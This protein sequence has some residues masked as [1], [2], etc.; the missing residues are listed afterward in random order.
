MSSAGFEPAIP[1]INWLQTYAIKGTACGIGFFKWLLFLIVS[2]RASDSGATEAFSSC[3]PIN[4]SIKTCRLAVPALRD[5]KT[6]SQTRQ[7][8]RVS[9]MNG[10][11]SLR[12]NGSRPRLKPIRCTS[13]CYFE[14]VTYGPCVYSVV[15]LRWRET[16]LEPWS[17]TSPL[18]M[19]RVK[20]KLIWT[21]GGVIIDWEQAISPEETRFYCHFVHHKY[22]T[23]C[24]WSEPGLCFNK[25]ATNNRNV[26]VGHLRYCTP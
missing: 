17:L 22:H 10:M 1:A 2:T 23:D 25:P 16:V 7:V 8:A 4:Y 5:A 15:F 3:I 20:D 14:E 6:N 19:A 24:P 13:C 12:T 26:S 9:K 11:T 21:I 18:P